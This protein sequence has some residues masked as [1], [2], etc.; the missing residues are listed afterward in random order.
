MTQ[1][2]P[3]RPVTV[4]PVTL[5]GPAF[6][7]IA[8]PCAIE[9]AEQFSL[10][11][12][13]TRS[14]G[15]VML[16]GGIFKLRTSPDSFQGLGNNG[17]AV[18]REIRDR[19]GMPVVS[20]VVDPRQIEVMCEAVDMFQVGTRNMY[21]Y[22]LLKELGLAGKPVLLKRGFSARLEEWM[23]AA[24]YILRGGNQDVVLCERGIRTFEVATRNTLDLSAV[25]LI[26]QTFELPV[27]VDPSHATGLRS[28]IEPMS[29][30]AAAAGADGLLLEVHNDPAAA[31]SDSEQSLDFEDF[32]GLM[33]R[34]KKL[35][36]G[37]NRPLHILP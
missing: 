14:L 8:G 1:P 11:A 12:E 23:L 20:E 22:A 6:T 35:L 28:L 17:L 33:D 2:S 34:L 26:K 29:L 4:G 9:S 7:V 3:T 18:A 36:G 19:V 25:A 30:A 16:R 13:K 31:L 21:N 15:A 10:I 5:G 37:L 27:L 32:S 24:E